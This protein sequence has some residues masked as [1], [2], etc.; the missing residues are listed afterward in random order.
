MIILPLQGFSQ[1][2]A[3]SISSELYAYKF[4]DSSHIRPY[5]RLRA[6][7]LAWQSAK[8]QKLE[9]NT[10][11]RWTTDLKTKLNTDPQLYIYEIY[12]HLSKMPA[13][14]DIYIGRQFVYNGLASAIIDGLRF[15]YDFGRKYQF[16]I[17]GGV[18]VS[19]LDPEKI[20]SLSESGTL[21]ARLSYKPA[22][23]TQLGINWIYRKIN[24]QINSHRLGIDIDQGIRHWRFFGQIAYNLS[25]LRLGGITSRISYNH[26]PW[27]WSGEFDWREPSV[28]DASVFS[29]LD[30]KRY[31]IVRSSIRRT[32]WR[33]IGITANFHS[34]FQS[35][36]NTY[37]VN[38]GIASA[39]YG[40]SWRY[41]TGP[42]GHNNGIDGFISIRLSSNWEIYGN[43]ILSRYK[44]QEEQ[45]TRIDDYSSHIGLSWRTRTGL[46]ASI[47][48]QFARNALASSQSRLYARMT[49][50]FSIALK[51]PKGK[52]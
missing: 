5:L 36:D 34:R 8:G 37:I 30:F 14:S 41:Q 47:E 50:Y 23:Q 7:L 28:S 33:D 9:I 1:K 48:G 35:G 10:N 38:L 27:Y 32:I 4:Q 51:S 46:A 11:L 19:G 17:F 25:W 15:R 18:A 13:N 40:I 44:V 21:G 6:N 2:L 24:G 49:K 52:P 43:G 39:S 12:A 42:D 20:Y 3:G 16:D 22:R 26:G 31:Q 45:D 29:I